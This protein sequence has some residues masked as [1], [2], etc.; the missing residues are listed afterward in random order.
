MIPVEK[1]KEYEI[2]IE[3]VTNEG[4]G[5]G[6]IEGFT[7][8]VPGSVRDDFLRVLIVKVNKGYAFGKILRVLEASPYRTESKCIYFD[9]CGGCQ[10]MHI[11]YS[12]Q[13]N[14]KAG[15][16]NDCLSRLGGQ[17]EYKFLGVIGMDKPYEY[18]NKLIFP[19]GTDKDNKPV[20]GFYAQRSHRVIPLSRCLLGDDLHE[21]VLGFVSEHVK[22]YNISV[23]DEEKHS[24]VLR[25]VFVRQG[26]ES[27]EAMVVLSVNAG[28]LKKQKELAENLMSA[29]GRIVSVILN[30]NTKKTNL[31]LGDENKTIA[32]KN[33][34][35]DILCGFKYEISPHSFF[36]VNPI[37]TEKLYNTAIEF[38]EIKETDRV[39]DV[40]CGIGTISLLASKY[41]K[42]V[43]G[44]EIVPQAIKDAEFNAKENN[45]DN[46]KFLCGAAE[47][48]VPKLLAEE[49]KPDVVIL[50]PPRKGSDEKTL[51]AIIDAKPDKIVYVSCNPATLARD[52]KFLSENGYKLTKVKGC[53]M[54]PHS[55]HIETVALLTKLKESKTVSI[56]LELDELEVTAP[57]IKATYSQIKEYVLNK[58]GFK[59]SSLNIAQVKKECGI[60]ERENYNKASGDYRQP[61]CP[62]HKVDAI[63]DAFERF[64]M[65]KINV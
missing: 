19:Y 43:V 42:E 11:D 57:E 64:S 26:F 16:I 39:L 60:I 27:D 46:A 10:I 40:Y 48:I 65:I 15:I 8:F 21:K 5:V 58:Y 37:Q 63:K 29:D 13:L 47:D 14:I 23:Y 34:I 12:E 22:K 1:N 6:H 45:V 4:N 54:F 62:K 44:V 33:K 2:K 36:Q 17:S 50:D 61:N 25:R 52:V 31:V 7:V 18:R 49:K 28:E 51:S 38:A 20:C 41:A 24:G 32:G 56:D 55:V 59:V 30:I 9:K 3:G 35:T 53:D